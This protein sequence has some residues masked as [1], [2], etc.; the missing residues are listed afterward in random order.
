MFAA[1]AIATLAAGGSGRAAVSGQGNTTRAPAQPRANESLLQKSVLPQL[2]RSDLIEWAIRVNGVHSK[3]RDV[4]EC[5]NL[6]VA[7]AASSSLKAMVGAVS[8]SFTHHFHLVRI[9]HLYLRGARCF[10]TTL[11]DPVRRLQSA[12]NSEKTAM[13]ITRS[14]LVRN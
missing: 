7:H 5:G 8:P 11:R 2:N 13:G 9:R 10:F 12:F 6:A 3:G 14:Q 1:V 4:S